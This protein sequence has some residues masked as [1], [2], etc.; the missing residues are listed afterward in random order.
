MSHSQ[1]DTTDWPILADNYEEN[2]DLDE[3]KEISVQEQ[4]RV[5]KP[6]MMRP[7][8]GY[9]DSSSDR[10]SC[11]R[12]GGQSGLGTDYSDLD[13]SEMPKSYDYGDARPG[14]DN[15]LR[16]EQVPR[17]LHFDRAAMETPQTLTTELDIN[18]PG[19]LHPSYFDTFRPEERPHK[20]SLYM[21]Q[22]PPTLSTR[23]QRAFVIAD[24][25]HTHR[26]DSLVTDTSVFSQSRQ[27]KS[28][29][30]RFDGIRNES[31]WDTISTDGHFND[32]EDYM[33]GASWTV[34]E[35]DSWDR[36]P[37]DHGQLQ[38]K[39][40]EQEPRRRKREENFLKQK[41]AAEEHQSFTRKLSL[42]HHAKEKVREKSKRDKKTE[43]RDAMSES[44]QEI[45][46]MTQQ[47]QIHQIGQPKEYSDLQQTLNSILA[48]E[49]KNKSRKKSERDD[50]RILLEVIS[51]LVEENNQVKWSFEELQTIIRAEF[52]NEMDTIIG[53]FQEMYPP[54]A[55][56]MLGDAFSPDVS[57]SGWQQ[58]G[59]SEGRSS[60]QT[61]NGNERSK[62]ESLNEIRDLN[63]TSRAKERMRRNS[64][65]FPKPQGYYGDQ[66][67]NI[68]PEQ[69]TPIE[70]QTGRRRN[71]ISNIESRLDLDI[72]R[73]RGG[74][75]LYPSDRS[76]LP[77]T[78]AN[79]D[80][81]VRQGRGAGQDYLNQSH[82]QN[83]PRAQSM[84]RISQPVFGF[85]MHGANGTIGGYSQPPLQ[86]LFKPFSYHCPPEYLSKPAPYRRYK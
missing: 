21:A 85:G 19:P 34:D 73:T 29:R 71:S 67:A 86:S 30:L 70:T 63:K 28:L 69:S 44:R 40:G 55:I 54:Q 41:I 74:G 83:L 65:Q 82:T 42:P 60:R 4:I 78:R 75:H 16:Y 6:R 52:R 24:S 23:Q 77:I 10:N 43:L 49:A 61:R 39:K 33:F 35:D 7:R 50:K 79:P 51:R 36:Y 11:R 15:R 72:T 18:S 46:R 13:N 9:G 1:V 68:L 8:L 81:E 48:M 76:R 47:R 26:P 53:Q 80:A 62:N 59:E 38:I 2:S 3:S 5:R 25:Q 22:V 27:N 45:S 14:F 32:D 56:G 57:R 66:V 20:R 58:G 12:F 64:S 37:I 84:V 17:S 31:K